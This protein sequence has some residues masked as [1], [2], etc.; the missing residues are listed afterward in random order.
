MPKLVIALVFFVDII[1]FA[2]IKYFFVI[3]PL[4]FLPII[5]KVFLKLV[6]SCGVE[7]MITIKEYFVY[8]KPRGPAHLS[9]NGAFY[10]YDFYACKLK[11]EYANIDNPQEQVITLVRLQNLCRHV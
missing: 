8:I 6:N 7:N 3:M 9:E 4:F 1:F 2:R 5:L 10:Y 11:P